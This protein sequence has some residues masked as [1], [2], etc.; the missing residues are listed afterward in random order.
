MLT[1]YLNQN[2]ACYG[3]FPAHDRLW[4]SAA[5]TSDD[6]LSRLAIVPLVLEARGLD[7]TPGAIKKLS[8]TSDTK[9]ARILKITG[10]EEI[11]HV[12]TGVLWFHHICKCR[13]LK[14]ASTFQ[15]L[16]K[17]QLNGFLKLPLAT[18]ARTLAGFPRFH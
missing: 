1:N 7:T 16:V 13:E 10:E 5:K 3:D 11:F 15:L 12:A 18:N 17:S 9:A 4:E 14:P 6:I 2:N 8:T